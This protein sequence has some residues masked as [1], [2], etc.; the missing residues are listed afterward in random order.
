VL[1][2]IMGLQNAV[3]TKISHAEIRTTHV[4]GLVTDLGIELG[5][6]LYINRLTR[7]TRVAANRNKLRIQL[8]LIA[9]FFIGGLVGAVGFKSVGFIATVPLAI[10]LALLVIRPVLNDA[11]NWIDP[12]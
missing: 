1:C 3:I 4:T 11:K 10:L 8:A 2:F 5:K 6:L 9:S 7:E 12:H